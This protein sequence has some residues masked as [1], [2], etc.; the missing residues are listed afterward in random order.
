[1]YTFGNSAVTTMKKNP[2]HLKKNVYCTGKCK[3]WM[4]DKSLS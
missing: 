2:I 4:S 1:M 3:T